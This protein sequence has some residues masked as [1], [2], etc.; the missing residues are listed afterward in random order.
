MLEVSVLVR[1]DFVWT[2]YRITNNSED[3][4]AEFFKAINDREWIEAHKNLKN[5]K[6]LMAALKIK[7]GRLSRSSYY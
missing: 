7:D 1:K 4:L 5:E 2:D 6:E 3:A